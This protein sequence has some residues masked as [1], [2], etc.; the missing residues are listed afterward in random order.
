MGKRLFA[1]ALAVLLCA[2][3]LPGIV[4]ASET[5]A[6]EEE[7]TIPFEDVSPDAWYYGDVKTAAESGLVN[8]KTETT[9]CPD[10]CLT[11]AEA[12]KLAACMNQ[13]YAE[14]TVS[15]TNGDPWYQTYAD[16]ARARGIIAGEYDWGAEINR[17]GYMGIFAR[18]LPDSALTAKNPV[19]DGA[20]PDVPMTHP[21]AAGIYKLYRAG[22]V[23][24]DEEHFCHPDDPIR[25]SEVAAILTRMMNV[26]E[27]K[28]LSLGAEKILAESTLRITKHPVSVAL[29]TED[30]TAS[31]TVEIAG[32]TAPFIYKWVIERETGSSPTS[33]TSGA[34]TSTFSAAFPK[35]S[36]SETKP[37]FVY[38]VVTDSEGKSVQS[39]KAGVTPYSETLRVTKQP[40]DFTIRTAGE[41][42]ASFSVE[43][44]GGKPPYS[45]DWREELATRT[46]SI[47]Q[48]SSG[49]RNTLNLTDADQILSQGAEP[50]VYCIVSDSAGNK[51]VTDR[52]K[53]KTAYLAASI[54]PLDVVLSSSADSFTLVT[55][56]TGGVEPYSFQWY[57]GFRADRMEDM[58][59]WTAGY[60]TPGLTARPDPRYPVQYLSCRVR[61]DAGTEVFT[62]AVSVRIA[63]KDAG[64]PEVPAVEPEPD[65]DPDLSAGGEN[66]DPLRILVHP[67]SLTAAEGEQVMFLVEAAGGSGSYRYEWQ[68]TNGAKDGA[69]TSCG[70]A[71]EDVSAI[72]FTA[73]GDC[74]DDQSQFRVRCVVTDGETGETAVSDAAGIFR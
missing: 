37:A 46:V 11:W 47:Q 69:W 26:G 73:R 53:L 52:V 19:A 66:A 48:A 20:I 67:A 2:G 58:S 59:G 10:D 38:C 74:F 6:G 22:V 24:G 72:A 45:Y 1:L 65:R 28:S 13:K 36:V 3:V 17:A 21:Q 41:K 5:A 43:I 18:A 56:V 54:E 64:W 60:D 51:A 40:E 4:P 50:A 49:T 68:W 27:R 55:A 31:F 57:W 23:Q 7:E 61:D 16:Y 71:L 32:G 34:R 42:N 63:G 15:L 29:L 44:A 70:P 39:E 14:G 25:R 30:E 12:V 33:R 9:F 8:G 62:P 35:D